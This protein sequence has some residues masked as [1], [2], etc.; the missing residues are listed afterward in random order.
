MESLG[1]YLPEIWL[2]II[3][4]FVLYYAVTDGSDLGVG[5]LSF[6]ARDDR[7]RG[8]MMASV[9]SIWHGN[10][11]WL[12]L[13][14]GMVFGAFPFF[15]GVVVASLYIP[16]LIMLF[17]LIFRAVSLE[18]RGHSERK[19]LWG[20]FFGI[21]S[22]ATTLAQ[23]VAL[24]GLLGGLD[25]DQGK[26][27]GSSWGWL[28]PYSI[29][30][31]A[32]VL[33]GYTMLGAN[34]LILKTEGELQRKCYRYSFLASTVTLAIAAVVHLWTNARHAFM[35]EKWFHLPDVF[36]VL[37]FPLLALVAFGMFYY[38]LWKRYELAP[39]VWNAAV[40]LFSFVG[41]SIGFYPYMIPSVVAVPVTIAAAAASPSTLRFMLV[42]TLVL[43]PIIL[44]YTAFEH[45]VFHGKVTD[46]YGE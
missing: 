31:A 5:I 18:F 45:K 11:T 43:L 22:L 2:T 25:I 39:L 14:G 17:G 13:L 35:L 4:L 6:L 34:Y 12:V 27:I 29:V 32:G 19:E 16:I 40:V 36:L 37:L 38:S 24:G 9:K 30:V 44:T 33:A 20:L 42:V 23:G 15:Y 26:F 3:G 7:E 10:Q 8:L 41:L 21:G 28:N 46:D 1:V